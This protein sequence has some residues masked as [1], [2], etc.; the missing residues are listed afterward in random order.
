VLVLVPL[1]L[2][3]AS[4]PEQSVEVFFSP[5]GGCTDAVVRELGQA[6]QSV[7]IQ[8]YSFTSTPIAKAIVEAKK[9][10][11]R[12]EAVLDKSNR[13]DKYSAA[14]FLKNQGVDVLI[15]DKHAIAH[16]KIMIIDDAVVITGSF[17]FTKAAEESNAENL[18]VIRGQP[19]L[20]RKYVANYDA[21][22]THSQ[23]YERAQGTK[24][25]P[26]RRGRR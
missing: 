11:V 23:V 26:E 1:L 21:H 13:S 5:H 16:N 9:R 4:P 17:N 2:S 20:V 15:D 8:A 6:K 19:D 14:T 12:V 3:A 18:L 24:G 22:R 10:G 25:E 7:R